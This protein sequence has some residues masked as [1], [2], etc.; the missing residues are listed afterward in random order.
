MRVISLI[1]KPSNPTSSLAATLVY[2]FRKDALHHVAD[3]IKSG[4][5]DRAGDLIAYMCQKE[6]I[7]GSVLQGRWFDIG[8]LEQL[9]KAEEWIQLKSR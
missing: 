5:S 7:Y 3:V 1:E 6:A 9:K 4:K 2:I 8:T